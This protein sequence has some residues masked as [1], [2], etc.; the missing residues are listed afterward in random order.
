MIVCCRL[1]FNLIYKISMENTLEK[2][3]EF[4]DMIADFF[5]EIDPARVRMIEW[6]RDFIKQIILLSAWIIAFSIPILDNWWLVSL[7]RLFSISQIIFVLLIIAWVFYFYRIN[8]QEEKTY[9]SIVSPFMSINKNTNPD[10]FMLGFI[11]HLWKLPKQLP[12]YKK[13]ETFEKIIT[14]FLTRWFIGALILMVI[15]LF[16]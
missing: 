16:T 2:N 8:K 1:K 9:K 5:N 11:N 7:K 13:F 6:K 12:Y 10:D 15:S 14:L 3:I 4:I